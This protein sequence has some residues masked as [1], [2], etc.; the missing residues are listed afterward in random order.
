MNF[1]RLFGQFLVMLI[2]SPLVL[3]ATPFWMPELLLSR[4]ARNSARWAKLAEDESGLDW[5]FSLRDPHPHPSGQSFVRLWGV[6]FRY[7]D[8]NSGLQGF[9]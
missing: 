4:E 1:V 9:M 3:F 6:E 5:M 8:C 7:N 2:V